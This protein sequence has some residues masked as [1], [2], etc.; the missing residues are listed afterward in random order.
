MHQIV[1]QGGEIPSPNLFLYSGKIGNQC[2][3]R[4]GIGNSL[5]YQPDTGTKLLSYSFFYIK[6]SST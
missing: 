2:A 5:P 6:N 4:M 3:K 1:K